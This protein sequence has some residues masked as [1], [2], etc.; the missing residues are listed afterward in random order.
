[1]IKKLA[2]KLPM[3]GDKLTE[4]IENKNSHRDDR[5]GGIIIKFIQQIYRRAY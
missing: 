4:G 2:S 3:E 1:M 5:R